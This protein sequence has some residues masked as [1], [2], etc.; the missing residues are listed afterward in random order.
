LK[1]GDYQVA[2]KGRNYIVNQAAGGI[3][4]SDELHQFYQSDYLPANKKRY[5]Y[6]KNL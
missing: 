4:R 2:F 1:E 6:F 3:R 5:A